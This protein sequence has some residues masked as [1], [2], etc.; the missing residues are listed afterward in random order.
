MAAGGL[1]RA[2][3]VYSADGNLKGLWSG[4][5][6]AW[7]LVSD[8][9]DQKY[10]DVESMDPSAWACGAA[11]GAS[12]VGPI[13]WSGVK[14]KMGWVRCPGEGSRSFQR[15]TFAASCLGAPTAPFGVNS[16]IDA[17]LDSDGMRPVR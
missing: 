16:G 7:D 4:A 15:C 13:T 1:A 9:G 10:L 2:R 11:P 8:C 5:S 17:E 14:Q 6:K 12:C 3:A